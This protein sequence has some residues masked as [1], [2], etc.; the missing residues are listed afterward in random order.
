MQGA[1]HPQYHKEMATYMGVSQN[2]VPL[3]AWV[4][5]S[6]PSYPYRNQPFFLPASPSA[7][8]SSELQKRTRVCVR[9]WCRGKAGRIP[10]KGVKTCQTPLHGGW[11]R[12]Q[13]PAPNPQ[14]A[15]A[16][17][18]S[19]QPAPAPSPQPPAQGLNSGL[20]PHLT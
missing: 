3:N 11:G 9:S 20:T 8:L 5:S 16:P 4:P 7:D 14:P 13:P 12:P 1:I 2:T 17:A 18:P 6:F 15:P 10:R 19:H